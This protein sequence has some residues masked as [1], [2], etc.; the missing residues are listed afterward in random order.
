MVVCRIVAPAVA[1]A[2]VAFHLVAPPRRHLLPR[3]SRGNRVRRDTP[4]VL[5]RKMPVPVLLLIS[6]VAVVVVV[7]TVTV[8]GVVVPAALRRDRH[9]DKMQSPWLLNLSRSRWPM[10]S[11][12]PQLLVDDILLQSFAVLVMVVRTAVVVVVDTPSVVP[13]RRQRLPLVFVNV[14]EAAA[15][16]D[17]V[18]NRAAFSQRCLLP[19]PAGDDER[20]VF[21][22]V[23]SSRT[24]P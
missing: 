7:D 15:L 1:Q 13:L 24:D 5:H 11:P 20:I 17:V 10:R 9:S 14:V 12:P 19:V 18:D 8:V 2:C 16:F 3:D 22:L 6:V 4:V 23:R 21:C